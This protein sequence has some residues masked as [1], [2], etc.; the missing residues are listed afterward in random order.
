MELRYNADLKYVVTPAVFFFYIY[1]QLH[2]VLLLKSEGVV[3]YRTLKN[4]YS[5][6]KK[7]DTVW[8]ISLVINVNKTATT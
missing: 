8:K 4:P 5:R 7:H 1:L 2:K 3:V 6:Y